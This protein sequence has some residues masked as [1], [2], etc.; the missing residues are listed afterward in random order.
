LPIDPRSTHR[1]HLKHR[2]V[3]LTGFVAGLSDLYKS[4]DGLKPI[5]W[6]DMKRPYYGLFDTAR[7]MDSANIIGDDINDLA[8][9]PY[10]ADGLAEAIS[11]LANSLAEQN[12]DE[13]EIHSRP[14]ELTTRSLARWPEFS[15]IATSTA[16]FRTYSFT[17]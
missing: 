13:Y 3:R 4:A 14:Q 15:P 2:A 6:S 5:H 10:D 7:S 9:K 1:A 12:T 16:P 11:G 17:K 8:V